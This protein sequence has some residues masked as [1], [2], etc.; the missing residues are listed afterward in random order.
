M[1][2]PLEDRLLLAAS[3]EEF[4][5]RSTGG[6]ITG[7]TSGVNGDPNLYFTMPSTNSIGVYNPETAGP[8]SAYPIPTV[9]ANAQNL[10]VGNS[11]AGDLVAGADG[12]IYFLETAANQ[13]GVF[14]PTLDR[15]IAEYPILSSS[16]AGLQAITSGPDGN[17]WFTESLQNEIGEFNITTHLITDFNVPT[18]LSNP[19]GITSDPADN[20]VWFTESNT[21]NIGE[22][23]LETHVFS[24]FN[25]GSSSLNP[26]NITYDSVNGKVYFV[27]TQTKSIGWLNAMNPTTAQ[28]ATGLLDTSISDDLTADP[29]GNIW[30]T[31]KTTASITLLNISTEKISS[32]YTR[33]TTDGVTLGSDGRLWV[34]VAG[35]GSIGYSPN[36]QPFSTA[37]VPGTAI[38]IPGTAGTTPDYTTPG[39]VVTDAIGNLWFATSKSD[40]NQIDSLSLTTQETY[41]YTLQFPN[42]QGQYFFVTAL[43]SILR[44][45]RFTSPM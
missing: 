40:F 31:T 42:P 30:A 23:N 22:L 38:V 25:L 39:A 28:S 32:F 21:N 9:N 34:A 6:N 2:E 24:Q 3:V 16:N 18:S 44:T 14:S 36:I 10:A 45:N 12:N 5:L 20:A 26:G 7:I 33:T 41:E 11:G 43:A 27:E 17:I 13:I 19:Y 35:I 4:P 8:V 37:G 29:N 1:L 15:V